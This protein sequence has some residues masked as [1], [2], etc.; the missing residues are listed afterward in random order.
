MAL[1]GLVFTAGSAMELAASALVSVPLYLAEISPPSIRGF[2]I[3]LHEILNQLS[4]V[5]GFWVNYGTLQFF[6]NKQWMIPLGMQMAPGALLFLAC[7]ILPESPTRLPESPRFLVRKGMIED[8]GKN[9]GCIRGFGRG[10]T[11]N[12]SI[13][14]G[15]R[16]CVS[17]ELGDIVIQADN[18]RR[19]I[20]AGK[21]RR[22]IG[23]KNWEDY[24]RLGGI[25]RQGDVRRL[26][27]GVSLMAC[28]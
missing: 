26:G 25:F 3:G 7:L 10:W 5:T 23:E 22:S 8:A 24:V 17:K 27:I 12:E 15:G 21:T 13:I 14:E 19:E 28:Q 18:E 11:T 4:G 16:E 2:M 20:A 6:G 1:A 9:L